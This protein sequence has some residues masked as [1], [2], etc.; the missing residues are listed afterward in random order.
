MPVAIAEMGMPGVQR[1]PMPAQVD[2]GCRV[3]L[4][5]IDGQGLPGK[6]SGSTADAVAGRALDLRYCSVEFGD[7]VRPITL[8][9]G[10]HV[11]RTTPGTR[12][13]IDVD[14]L[15]LASDAG[16]V[17]MPLDDGGKLPASLLRS[18]SGPPA[19]PTVKVTSKGS[20][21]IE[22]Q[23]TGARKGTPFW[24]VLGESNN[25]GWEAKVDGS[26][27]G[28]STLG[29]GYAN[30]WRVH[31][32]SGSFSVTLTWTPQQKVWIAIAVSVVAVPL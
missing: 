14:S 6:L 8:A 23:V 18:T 22:L 17:M 20:T 16:G 5:S 4:M 28:G 12:S 11:L 30:G 9:Q 10:D 27:I 13:G 21:K 2:T 31:P 24:L 29:D 7:E 32:P 26:N 3:G 15:T 25:A 1:A 19:Q